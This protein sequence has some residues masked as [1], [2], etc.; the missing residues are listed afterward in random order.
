MAREAVLEYLR[1]NYKHPT[2]VSW[3]SWLDEPTNSSGEYISTTFNYIADDWTIRI[4]SSLETPE[5]SIYAIQ[6]NAPALGFEWLGLVDALGQVVET[7]V[8]FSDALN[9]ESVELQPTRTT[10]NTITPTHTYF[11]SSNAYADP[12]YPHSCPGPLQ[13]SQFPG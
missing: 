11:H 9:E 4:S 12:T 7:S 5:A 10:A 13:C 6:V 3:I 1:V 8:T 2:P